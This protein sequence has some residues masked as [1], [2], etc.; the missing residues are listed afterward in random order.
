MCQVK[1]KTIAA[2]RSGVKVLIFPKANKPDFEELLPHV[3][4]G[5]EVKFVEHYKEIYSV[6]F[7]E[8]QEEMK[9]DDSS[10][11]EKE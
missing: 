9:T 8:E 1:E 3:R 4:E 10:P 7:G 6:A 5:F 2:R 11:A